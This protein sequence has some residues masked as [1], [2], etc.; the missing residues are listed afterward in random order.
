MVGDRYTEYHRLR[1]RRAGDAAGQ[2]D[3]RLTIVAGL[4][5]IALPVGV[6]ASAFANVVHR[7]DFIITWGMVARVPLFSGLSARQIADVMELLRAQRAEPG[8]IIVRRGEPAHSMYFIAAGEVE[9]DIKNERI[10]LGTGHFFGEI[11]VLHQARRSA[12]VVATA[13]TSLLVLGAQDLQAL[14]E[15][16]PEI[17]S[18]LQ[19]VHERLQGGA[20]TSKGDLVEEEIGKSGRPSRGKPS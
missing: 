3:R 1:R 2:A 18:R 5:M 14:M 12:T 20:V 19:V 17:A 7:R 8:T 4:I 13:N 16:E 9:I 10:R 6:I 15:R 11:A